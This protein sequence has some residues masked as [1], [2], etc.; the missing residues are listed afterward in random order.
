MNLLTRVQLCPVSEELPLCFG[1][2]ETL[3]EVSRNDFVETTLRIARLGMFSG[4]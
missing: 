1:V 2:K 4:S 3:P